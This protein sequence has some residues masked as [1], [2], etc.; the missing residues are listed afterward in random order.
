M[1]EAPARAIPGAPGT[2]SR[3]P[4]ERVFHV[5]SSAYCWPHHRL[6]GTL[7][8][9]LC[10]DP[11]AMV[12]QG[13]GSRRS[14]ARSPAEACLEKDDAVPAAPGIGYLSAAPPD[15][16]TAMRMTIEIALCLSVAALPVWTM[17]FGGPFRLDRFSRAVFVYR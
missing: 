11:C 14:V 10:T 9:S 5:P 8:R 6:A 2:R 4:S 7:G 12:T 15:G 13:G 17:N 1:P 3:S 16:L